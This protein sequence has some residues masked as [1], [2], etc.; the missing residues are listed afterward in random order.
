MNLRIVSGNE[1]ISGQEKESSASLARTN[2]TN[3]DRAARGKL[4]LDRGTRANPDRGNTSRT[5]IAKS[6]N[7]G[8]GQT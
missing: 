8:K 5:G 7:H 1:A 3:L 6:V 4:S 2:L